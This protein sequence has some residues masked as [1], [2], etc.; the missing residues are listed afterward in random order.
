LYFTSRKTLEGLSDE[1]C[2]KKLEMALE[3]ATM[4]GVISKEPNDA[5]EDSIKVELGIKS[6]TFG[7]RSFPTIF[8][9][10]SFD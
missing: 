8:C 2:I 4:A 3:D 6:S 7:N 1:E 9:E 5:L 10:L